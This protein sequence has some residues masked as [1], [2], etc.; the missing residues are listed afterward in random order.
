MLSK[1]R[2]VSFTGLQLHSLPKTFENEE[3][4]KA[5]YYDEVIETIK[6][7]SGAYQVITFDHSK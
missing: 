6:R 4:I 5:E 2:A 7:L 3:K 1:R